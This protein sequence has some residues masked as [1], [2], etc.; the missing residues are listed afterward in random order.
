MELANNTDQ[1]TDFEYHVFYNSLFDKHEPL[2]LEYNSQERAWIQKIVCETEWEDIPDID[3]ILDWT[4]GKGKFITGMVK[5]LVYMNNQEQFMNYV[6]K[7][8]MRHLQEN[9]HFKSIKTKEDKI[10]I[11]IQSLTFLIE[12]C[13]IED[14]EIFEEMCESNI[15]ARFYT[16]LYNLGLRNLKKNSQPTKDNDDI[17]DIFKGRLTVLKKYLER[18]IK[19]QHA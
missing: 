2:V 4:Q 15:A 12:Y 9:E 13:D 14:M 1:S 17:K 10:L 6:T 7:T 3:K 18:I 16:A 11:L 5:Q 19:S 8:L